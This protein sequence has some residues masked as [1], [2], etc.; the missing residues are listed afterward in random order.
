MDCNSI[1]LFAKVLLSVPVAARS[2]T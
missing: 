2:K 1:L